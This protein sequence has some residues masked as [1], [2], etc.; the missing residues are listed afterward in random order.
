[1]N[2]TDHL[3]HGFHSRGHLPHLKREGSSY[4][5][6]FRLADSLPREAILRL[7]HEREALVQN[8]RIGKRPLT[9]REEQ[10]LFVWYSDKVESLL[11]AGAG[12]CWLRKSE[13][14]DL[15]ATALGHFAGARYDLFAWV[16]MPN[17]VHAVLWPR[18]K[19]TLSEILHS[20]KSF[21]SLKANR[22]LNRAGRRFWQKESY[23]HCIRDDDERSRLCAYTMNNP[24]KAGLCERAE[25]WRWSSA[26]PVAK[27]FLP[28]YVG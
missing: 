4:F 3:V 19:H 17:H 2:S 20:W 27:R 26:H 13:L 7:K 10:Q 24:V 18:P 22:L 15:V 11:D 25:E 16:I 21:T 23:S 9:W 14:A 6:T 8:A 28:G 1:M 5:I 12:A